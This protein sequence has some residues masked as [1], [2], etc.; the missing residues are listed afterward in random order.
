MTKL[1]ISLILI[2]TLYS[3]Q[4]QQQKFNQEKWLEVADLAT[5]PQRKSML[6]D[7]TKN[8]LLKG[9]SYPEIVSLLGQPQY[10]F[11]SSM[12][13]GYLIDVDYGI[14]IDPVYSQTLLLHFDKDSTVMYFEVD[15]WKK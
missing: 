11:D 12:N 1:F 13:I 3:C 15:E 6:D 14:D 4:T 7:L 5:F 8:I 9:K 2:A 10:S